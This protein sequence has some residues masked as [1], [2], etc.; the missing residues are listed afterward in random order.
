MCILHILN[1]YHNIGV[2]KK[3]IHFSP[4]LAVFDSRLVG[5]SAGWEKQ[6]PFLLDF[7]FTHI[8][9]AFEY[10]LQ[11]HPPSPGGWW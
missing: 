5:H 8:I 10:N 2:K 6:I 4:F 3:T 1:T 11:V 7:L 9:S